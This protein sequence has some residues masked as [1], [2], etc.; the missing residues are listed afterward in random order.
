MEDVKQQ[1]ELSKDDLLDVSL[2]NLPEDAKKTVK[3]VLT[4]KPALNAS[5]LSELRPANVPFRHVFELTEITVVYLSV[6]RM[7]NNNNDI[8]RK[9]IGK[10]MAAR[11]IRP[12][13][14]SWGF[15]VVIAK[16]KG[17]SS[18]F[19][20]NYRALNKRMKADKIPLLRI[21]EVIDDLAGSTIFSRLDTFASYWQIKLEKSIQKR[22]AFRSKFGSFQF[23][24]MPF[25]LMN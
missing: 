3:H 19:C 12:E 22:T 11:I 13:A 23:K 20:V 7:L 10:M 9:E 5:D 8:V 21:K 4:K 18:L 24:E 2:E 6:R 25:G 14:S 15:P 17:G 1:S 16:K